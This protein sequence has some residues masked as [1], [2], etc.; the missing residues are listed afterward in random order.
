MCRY[1]NR[2]VDPEIQ[3]VYRKMLSSI[4]LAELQTVWESYIMQPDIPAREPP[5]CNQLYAMWKRRKDEQKAKVKVKREA[6]APEK[7]D[8]EDTLRKLMFP[9]I[10]NALLGGAYKELTPGGDEPMPDWMQTIATWVRQQ[11]KSDHPDG[12]M[13]HDIA[14]KYYAMGL[15]LFDEERTSYETTA[16]D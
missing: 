5:K 3:E 2:K 7:T 9:A 11:Y 15:K 12:A 6:V 14:K 10:H 8:P 1:F 16:I 4:P 13:S